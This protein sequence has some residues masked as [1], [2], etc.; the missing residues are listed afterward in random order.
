MSSSLYRLLKLAP[1]LGMLVLINACKAPGDVTSDAMACFEHSGRNYS[2]VLGCYKKANALVAPD[3]KA[4]GVEQVGDVQITRYRLLSQAWGSN[5]TVAPAL[6][7]H[8]VEIYTPRTVLPDKPAILVVND[9][10]NNP[11]PGSPPG[12][13][14]NFTRDSLLRIARETGSSVVVVDDVPN[15]YLTY[16][17]DGKLR[18]EDDSVA[19]SWKLFMQAPAADPF[20]AVNVPAMEAVIKTMDLA[21]RELPVK[22]SGYIL[23]GASKR[24]WAV[25]LAMLL[26]K[27]VSAIAPIVIE[28]LNGKLAFD[29][30]YQVYGQSWPL[31]FIDYYREGVTAQRDSE[32]FDKLMRVI[33]P[34]RYVGTAYAPRLST[35]KYIIN[36][37]GDDFFVPDSSRNYYASLPGAKSLRSIPNSAHDIRAFIPDALIPFFKRIRAGRPLPTVVP[38]A[39]GAFRFSELPI[40]V[41]RWNANNPQARDFRFNCNIRYMPTPLPVS[42]TV[43]PLDAAPK[44]GWHAAFIEATFEDGMV[45]TTQVQIMPDTYPPLPPAPGGPFCQ[46]LPGPGPTD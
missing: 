22:A 8:R 44:A 14:N 32:A 38:V 26:D 19:H 20:M 11:L 15:Q 7:K 2:E 4:E 21:D 27:R 3:Y 36:A 30:A 9:G 12:A 25:W 43:G 37:S 42:Q 18:T 5:G 24:A 35:P 40:K 17:N 46:T 16:N 13:P 34:L 10:V 41:V 6:W 1:A 31:A 23:T 28:T 39:G 29:H 45:A 33:D